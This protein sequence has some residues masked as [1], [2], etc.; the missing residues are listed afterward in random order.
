MDETKQETYYRIYNTR[1]K[2]WVGRGG[3]CTDKREYS[4][5]YTT[6]KSAKMSFGRLNY[7]RNANTYLDS[8]WVILEFTATPKQHSMMLS[9]LK[10][11]TIQ[12]SVDDYIDNLLL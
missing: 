12:K 11:K 5:M 4:G 8:D 6:I 9:N 7:S 3:W 1:T 2:Q 10:Q